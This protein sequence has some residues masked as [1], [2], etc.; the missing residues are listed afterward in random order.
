MNDIHDTLGGGNPA[1]STTSMHPSYP[2]PQ[3]PHPETTED[4]A[5]L[6]AQ[7][8]DTQTLISTSVSRVISLEGR[9][10]EQEGVRREV[11]EL[12]ERLAMLAG[13][14]ELRSRMEDEDDDDEDGDEDGDEEADDDDDTR[15]VGTVKASSSPS[16]LRRNN[17]RKQHRAGS[18]DDK[19]DERAR[20]ADDDNDDDEPDRGRPATPEPGSKPREAAANGAAHRSGLRA[21]DLE[22]QQQQQDEHAGL[23]ERLAQQ[24]SDTQRVLAQN[25]SLAE[26][27][28]TLHTEL[29]GVLA[30]SR[31]LQTQH[32]SAL[33]T[34]TALESRV[35]ELEGKVTEVE[36]KWGA[37]KRTME[38]TWRRERESWDSERERMKSVV[39]EWE[40][41]KRR[42]EEEEEERRLNEEE[43]PD[44]LG[45][46][47]ADGSND[48]PDG[49]ASSGG[50]SSG[51]GADGD[52]GGTLQGG[53]ARFLARHGGQLDRS[54]SPTPNSSPDTKGRYSSLRHLLNPLFPVSSSPSPSGT[55]RGLSPG[56][57]GHT[58]GSVPSSFMRKGGAEAA[59]NVNGSAVSTGAGDSSSSHPLRKSASASTIK[60][61]S[62]GKS[63]ARPPAGRHSASSGSDEGALDD[64]QEDEKE[65]TITG[66]SAPVAAIR[67][68]GQPLQLSQV[69]LHIS[70]PSCR[71]AAG[72][73]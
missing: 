67:K 63:A 57:S 47:G 65:L 23:H 42:A 4:L 9:L 3:G 28:D 15:S 66:L 36:G 55:S 16:R 43:G 41:A 35:A 5:S 48:G 34:V 18:A 11:E 71:S 64:V 24:L 58:R 69:R 40:E 2:L 52:S 53:N 50:G 44:D 25:S 68:T 60:G 22:R 19:D 1:P 29:D 51:G 54:G 6:R 27:L 37:W 45:W 70:F 38:E 12:R 72:R 10:H 61:P 39:K 59:S 33:S 14:V 49:S 20:S 8:A 30:A 46:M 7:L 32:E 17:G 73:D 21:A 31:T 26:R 13:Q 62:V 56:K